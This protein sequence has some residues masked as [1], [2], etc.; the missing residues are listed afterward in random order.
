MKELEQYGSDG[1]AHGFEAVRR[2]G[3][4]GGA[5][6]GEKGEEEGGEGTSGADDEPG[7]E[8]EDEEKATE[9]AAE[10]REKMRN[11]LEEY[12]KLDYEDVVGG[13][14]KTRFRYR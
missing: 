1:E 13:D 12:Y 7:S 2:K 5:G 6:M 4:S 8:E 9:M 14:I 3:E 10:Q 11:M